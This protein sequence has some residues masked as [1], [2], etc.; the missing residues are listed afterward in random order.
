[1]ITIA[2]FIWIDNN[3]ICNH[4]DFFRKSSGAATKPAETTTK[5]EFESRPQSNEQEGLLH[6]SRPRHRNFLPATLAPFDSF[7]VPPFPEDGPLRAAR[8][9]AKESTADS[10]IFK[11][12]QN[13]ATELSDQARKAAKEKKEHN[14]TDTE[15]SQRESQTEKRS[16]DCE[17]ADPSVQ[18]SALETG[19]R[20]HFAID[21]RRTSKED[22]V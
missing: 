8:I 16:S 5:L 7:T 12:I 15:G 10:S 2:S 22:D 4:L 6:A 20:G 18:L 13:D 11:S 19:G 14:Q 9:S 1:V 17:P 3:V 21:I